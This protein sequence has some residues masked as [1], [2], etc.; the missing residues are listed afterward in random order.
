MQYCGTVFAAPTQR[1]IMKPRKLFMFLTISSH[2]LTLPTFKAPDKFIMT[3]LATKQLKSRKRNKKDYGAAT[4]HRSS[5]VPSV[6][7]HSYIDWISDSS[8]L[9]T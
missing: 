8:S 7:S 9:E 2:S 3:K 1:Q 6:I 5:F 4:I